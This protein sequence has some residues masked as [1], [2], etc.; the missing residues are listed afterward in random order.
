MAWEH[1]EQHS[2]QEWIDMLT[3]RLAAYED[4]G[5]TPE[6][7]SNVQECLLPIQFSRYYEIMAA[8]REGRLV[9]L[10]CVRPF[11]NGEYGIAWEVLEWDGRYGFMTANYKTQEEAEAAREEAEA[12]LKGGAE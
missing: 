6:E 12:A 7:I 2:T 3:E 11:D 10:P 1:E 9:I 8:E 5:L 4:T